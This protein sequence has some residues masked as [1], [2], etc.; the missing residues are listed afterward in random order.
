[1]SGETWAIVLAGGQGSRLRPLARRVC[2]DDRPKQFAPLV[3]P[4]SMLRATLDRVA[5]AMDPKRTAV[6]AL[7]DHVG[8]FADEMGQGLLPRVLVQPA[9]RGTA[10]AVLLAAHWISWRDP[11]ATLALFPSDHFIE[12]EVAFMDHVQEVAAFVRAHPEW[13]VLLGAE[14]TEPESEYGWIAPGA[15]VG[16]V[17]GDPVCRVLRFVEKP[18]RDEAQAWLAAGGLWN[19][20]V[21]VACAATLLAAGWRALPALSERLVRIQPFADSVDEP[22][23]LQQA[24]AFAPAANFSRAVLE[25][26]PPRLAVSRL[27]AP[28]VWSDWGTPDRVVR[29]LRGG[30]LTPPWLPDAE[31]L[32]AST[33]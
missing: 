9:D 11:E 21:V 13:I 16:M 17:G 22:W 28:V 6:V 20:L 10:A 23:A 31:R 19:T 24:Y 5:L 29:S 2:G 30:A 26:G 7:R 33:A 12:N 18:T 27:P 15:A 3:G 1:M 14:P 4:R 32:A 8:Y 25:P